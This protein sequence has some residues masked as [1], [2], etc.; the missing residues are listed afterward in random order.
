[1]NIYRSTDKLEI[2]QL[3]SAHRLWYGDYVRGDG[4]KEKYLIGIKTLNH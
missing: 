3:T 2:S 1:M 4:Y